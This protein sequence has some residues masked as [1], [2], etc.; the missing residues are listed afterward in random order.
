MCLIALFI[1][2]V[3]GVHRVSYGQAVPESFAN[4]P[5]SVQW[6]EMET[7]HFKIVFPQRFLDDPPMIGVMVEG[8]YQEYKIILGTA[9]DHKITLYIN[10]KDEVI[11]GIRALGTDESE[12]IWDENAYRQN[13][14]EAKQNMED[15]LRYEIAVVFQEDIQ[16]FP[17]DYYNY[18]LARPSKSPWSD[19]LPAYLTVPKQKY[20]DTRLMRNYWYSQ[21]MESDRLYWSR[22]STNIIVGRSQQFYFNNRFTSDS[23]G[24]IYIYNQSLAGLIDYFNF[25]PAFNHATG[26]DY[27]DF[28]NQWKNDRSDAYQRMKSGAAS[29][30]KGERFTPLLTQ[31][32][33]REYMGISVQSTGGYIATITLPAT[34]RLLEQLTVLQS[35][36]VEDEMVKI[37]EGFF[38][39]AVA[40]HPAKDELVYSKRIFNGDKGNYH[41]EL[42][43]SHAAGKNSRQITKNKH[44][45][46][47]AFSPDGGW[48]AYV[49]NNR[50]ESSIWKKNLKSEEQQVIYTFKGDTTVGHL[51]WHPDRDLLLLSFGTGEG[52]QKAGIL[53]MKKRTFSE[54]SL[55][56]VVPMD[57]RWSADGGSIY[58]NGIKQQVPNIF[59]A[60][61]TGDSVSDI[62]PV[63]SVF[64]GAAL[65]D[66]IADTSGNSRLLA[67][68]LASYGR[69]KVTEFSGEPL[70]ETGI[71]NAFNTDGS[72]TAA[73]Q[74]QKKISDQT[75][76]SSSAA[77]ITTRPYN[78]FLNI[79]WEPPFPV[80]YYLNPG[81]FGLAG[82]ISLLEP[83]H[84]HEFGF[85][86][87]LSLAAPIKKSYF[88]SSYVNNTLKPRLELTFNRFPAASDFFGNV[89]QVETTNV[90]ALSS[91]W[92]INALSSG[93]SN[94]YAGLVFRHQA[95][96]YFPEGTLQ[97]N[98]PGIFFDNQFT[99]QTDLKASLTWR[100]LRPYRHTLIHPLDGTGMRFSVTASDDVAGSQT[101][102]ARLNFES[103]TILAGGGNNR[104]FLYG[105]GALDLGEPAG[106]DYLGFTDSGNYQLPGPNFIGSINPGLDRFVRGYDTNVLGERFLFGTAEYRI[107]LIL[108]TSKK[109]LGFIPPARTA[110]AF[111]SDG[112][113]LGEARVAADRTTHVYR[114]SLGAEIKRVFSIG[115]SYKFLYELGITQPLNQSL[116]P[117]IYFNVKTS[118]PF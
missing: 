46:L 3:A 72:D 60:T 39:P 118:I 1:T 36:G 69:S 105:N 2:L 117:N 15:A 18:L 65:W 74:K 96:D 112:G 111:F 33:V 59:T 42:F 90:I 101:Q 28:S 31:N 109:L 45:I 30:T 37:D 62:Q 80:P 93:Y 53:A 21:A 107:P 48:L 106:R 19:G 51:A 82:Y 58:F 6:V 99:R 7:E 83:L 92:K 10:D 77:S 75:K 35:N 103:Y 54:F 104:I 26:T 86:G 76:A 84:N 78:S 5:A 95:F 67:Q 50:R 108:D 113:I 38:H 40:W 70:T 34:G 79:K 12:S 57:A 116:A 13:V 17:V 97:R 41:N 94:W 29:D 56:G 68:T 66:V 73:K 14:S 52:K 98:H 11:S 71:E 16:Y 88:Y 110:L 8:I 64:Q 20:Y 23:I 89:Q 55:E 61:F 22:E 32:G 44:A 81:D 4:N 87:I 85:T 102:Y 47:P 63:T 24:A 100:T 43:I 49:S 115:G 114:Y 91:L 9:P 25:N 27:T